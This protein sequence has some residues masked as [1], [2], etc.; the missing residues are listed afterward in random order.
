M[1]F[2]PVRRYISRNS[3]PYGYWI[4]EHQF[5]QLSAAHWTTDNLRIPGIPLRLDRKSTFL[6]STHLPRRKFIASKPDRFQNKAM[7]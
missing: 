1:S 4:S 3:A 6:Y 5:A 2:R 7:Q